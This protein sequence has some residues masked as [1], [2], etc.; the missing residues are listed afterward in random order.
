MGSNLDFGCFNLIVHS[1]MTFP[2]LGMTV[3]IVAH[4]LSTVRN[5][6]IIFVIKEGQVVEQGKH[7][8]LL[9]DEDGYYASLIRRQMETKEKLD[10]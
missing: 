8:D 5:A 4:R 9:E 10:G 1:V 7:G 6:D 2:Q 3:M